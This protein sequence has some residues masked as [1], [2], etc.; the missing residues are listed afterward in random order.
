MKVVI[1]HE[2]FL[3]Q[4]IEL[5]YTGL[6]IG[7]IHAFNHFTQKVGLITDRVLMTNS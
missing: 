7:E 3:P 6:A 4:H 5:I 2:A 1:R